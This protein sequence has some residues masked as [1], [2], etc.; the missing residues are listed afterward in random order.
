MDVTLTINGAEWSRKLAT[1][2]VDYKT[3]YAKIITTLDNVEHPCGGYQRAIVTFSLFP[4]TDE[5]CSE[6]FNELSQL[7]MSVTFTDPNR[8]D[9]T[10]KMRLTSDI[11]N[12]FALRS[13]DGKR[14][15]MGG[16]ITLRQV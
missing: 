8:G 6:L 12:S 11:S 16:K 5:E 7:I 10:L 14:R 15:Y 4:L 3:T 13:V 1:Y 9:M 2:K